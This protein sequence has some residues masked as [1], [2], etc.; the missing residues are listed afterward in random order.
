[1]SKFKP[2]SAPPVI[3]PAQRYSLNESAAILRVGIAQ[4]FRDAKAGKLVTFK[5]GRRTY[6]SGAEL[7]RRSRPP[8]RRTSTSD[9]G[10]RV[11]AP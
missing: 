8:Q 1:M 4:V 11:A 9:P 6:V 3:D 2:V 10:P 5:D 7:I